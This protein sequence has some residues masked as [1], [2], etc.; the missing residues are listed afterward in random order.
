[1]DASG[2]PLGATS[3]T[4]LPSGHAA[5]N[6]S[7]WLSQPF[8][9]SVQIVSDIPI[10][11]LSLN[12]E[13]YTQAAP[14]ISS[15][16]PG[17]LDSSTPLASGTGGWTSPAG[18]FTNTYYFPHFALGQGWQSVL[19]YVNYSP[20]SVSCQTSFLSDAGAPL[21]VP[22]G[23]AASSTRTDILP[24]GGEIH[25]LSAAAPDVA[26]GWAQGQ[27]AGPVKASMLFRLFNI[28]GV[29]LTEAGVNATG[30]PT[31]KFVTFAQTN[32]GIAFA[33]PSTAQSASV[34][35][36]ALNSSGAQLAST[37]LILPPSGHTAANV[38]SWASQSFNGSVQ[39]VSNIPIVSLS[40][41]AEAYTQAFP[42]VSSLPP[43]DLDGSTVLSTGH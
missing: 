15:L 10:V 27:C 9:G 39:I 38:S 24:P 42:V 33:N 4:L 16:P 40:L 11:S 14:V 1:M 7:S 29:A 17:D 43:G 25:V 12:A 26:G 35:I 31:T 18:P 41:N 21:L 5:S 2:A 34:T 3:L 20:Q 8:T 30:A 19:T 6:V 28:E 13:A 36:T 37:N 22:F 23:G 32:T